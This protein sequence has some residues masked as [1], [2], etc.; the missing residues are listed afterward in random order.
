MNTT[1]L[2][3]LEIQVDYLLHVT[4]KLKNENNQLR[5]KLASCIRNNTLL[6]ERNQQ[7]ANNVVQIINQ[8]KEKIS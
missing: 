6:K 2:S 5:D 8:L 7:A 1:E 4:Q 3:D